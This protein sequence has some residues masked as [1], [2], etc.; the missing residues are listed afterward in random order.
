[1]ADKP[2]AGGACVL[3]LVLMLRVPMETACLNDDVS[4]G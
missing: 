3:E 2:N 1:M 4:P